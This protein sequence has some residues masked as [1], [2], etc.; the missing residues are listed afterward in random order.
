MKLR[1]AS[2][3]A[4]RFEAPGAAT[5]VI[6][7]RVPKDRGS[8]TLGA[9]AEAPSPLFRGPACRSRISPRDPRINDPRIKEGHEIRVNYGYADGSGEYYLRIDTDRCDSCGDCVRACP[10]EILEMAADDCGESK[11]VVKPEFGQSLGYACLGYH[12]HCREREVNCHAA[13][14][15]DAI[16]HSW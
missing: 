15:P 12:A 16:E 1:G 11:A 10:E 9:A 7:W 6:C 14:R 8:S 2:R 5:A 4:P 13:C 3:E